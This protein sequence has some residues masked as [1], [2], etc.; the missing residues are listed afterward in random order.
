MSSE[1]TATTEASP[2]PAS[3]PQSRAARHA[4]VPG[5]RAKRPLTRRRTAEAV[6]PSRTSDWRSSWSVALRMARR[7]VRR[8]RGRSAVVALMVAIPMVLLSWLAT[9]GALTLSG[10]QVSPDR[11]LG[12][13]SAQVSSPMPYQILQDGSSGS[14]VEVIDPSSETR[15]PLEATPIP[16]YDPAASL[17]ANASAI[18][19]VTGGVATPVLES[20]VRV[21]IGERNVSMELLALDG[22][23]GFG[24]KLSLVSGRWPSGPTEALVS[25]PGIR[26]G[27]PA[28][29][30]FSL[31]TADGPVSV[32]VTGVG[33]GVNM[34]GRVPHLISS[35]QLRDAGT[36][37]PSSQGGRWLITGTD[38]PF[39]TVS[40]LGEYG[41]PVASGE[42]MADPVPDGEL[43]P[44]LLE[45]RWSPGG[46]DA[47]FV[48]AAAVVLA[49]VIGLLV[50]PAFAVSAGRQR[51]TLAL[52]AS[53]GATTRQLR[54]TVLAQAIVL[55]VLSAV[56]GAGLGIAIAAGMGYWTYRTSTTV[57]L[58]W[59]E[60]PW[61]IIAGFVL[62]AVIASVAAA[63]I[64]AR[65]LGRLDIM[66]VLKGQNVSP[67]PSRVV[68]VIGLVLMILGG[69]AIALGMRRPSGG[70]YIVA[71]GTFA[72]VVG[73]LM[74]VPM[75]LTVIARVAQGLP[76]PLRM[77]A[78]DAGR[79]RT[80]SAPTVAAVMGGVTL[81]TV[82]LIATTSDEAEAE[83]FYTPSTV[84]GEGILRPNESQ[85]SE[86]A[87]AVVAE[88]LPDATTV[89]VV[90]LGDHSWLY[91]EV[92]EG[93]PTDYLI[94]TAPGCSGDKAVFDKEW[95]DAQE[96]A[97]ADASD[98]NSFTWESAPCAGL[99][100]PMG[101]GGS[102]LALPTAA[103]V[104]RLDLSD[105]QAQQV[106]D[107][108]VVLFADDPLSAAASVTAFTGTYA[109]GSDYLPT[110]VMV[111]DERELAVITL[112]A[113]ERTSGLALD[114][115]T[116]ALVPLEVAEAADWPVGPP[117]YLVQGVDGSIG[118]ADE[119]RVS[120]RLNNADFSVERGFTSELTVFFG[121]L[122]AGI[123]F[124]LLVVVLTS[125]ALSMA[126]QRRDD[127]T[128]AAVG[129]TRGTRRA[130][131]AAQAF[132]A[133]GLG[134]LLGLVVGV[135]PGLAFAYVLTRTQGINQGNMTVWDPDA[136]TG[137]FIAV[138]Y[139]WLAVVVV[140]VPV[141][142]A[143]LSALAVRRAPVVTR[144]A[145]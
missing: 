97:Y 71:P 102:I 87:L 134:T 69:A 37:P 39:S 13:A 91:G 10:S 119:R 21:R 38:M 6:E 118:E 132:V 125:T 54:R 141:V 20:T 5:R 96:A 16:G 107:G 103:L 64:P 12:S 120:E 140:A 26:K 11:Q 81:L 143:L 137:P 73:A 142:A 35:E 1:T 27:L 56:V 129:A 100:S 48:S 57:I 105:A 14:F 24:D 114:V 77:A 63:L 23:V 45:I 2:G 53:N 52:A 123:G 144:R 3:Q 115:G 135:V 47:F 128:L 133:A 28:S 50:A 58:P 139:A 43:P 138:P 130:M 76:L 44:E 42:L 22:R 99:G 85:D 46:E 126:E 8:N 89:P 40:A 60:V 55:G 79:Q 112:P 41:L 82:T 80:R 88:T 4:K 25:E 30:T 34:F 122:I 67:A 124:I 72:L 33:T 92:A 51:H 113:S 95:Q 18:A 98:S 32:T 15:T 70:D 94:L 84:M 104:S 110:E 31:V 59:F 36:P 61:L 62:I 108:A 93:A 131:A 9:M 90:P 145:D 17:A 121:I 109:L 74:L 101:R 19:G 49:L 136:I 111:T 29:G 116:A 75:A 68:P 66:G 83:H 78:R 65:R 127:S 7:E 117:F 86:A 106:R